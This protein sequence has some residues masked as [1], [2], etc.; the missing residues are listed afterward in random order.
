MRAKLSLT[1]HIKVNQ[2]YI[3]VLLIKIFIVTLFL[4]YRVSNV[5]LILMLLFWIVSGDYLNSLQALRQKKILML[6]I[7]FYLVHVVALLYS[8]NLFNAY[9]ELEKKIPLLLFPLIVASMKEETLRLKR[10]ELLAFY[11]TVT[12]ITCGLLV[13]YAAYR[14]MAEGNVEVFYF[15]EFTALIQVNAIYLAMYVLFA[16]G[17]YFYELNTRSKKADLVKKVLVYLASL[18]VLMFIS[19]KTALAVFILLSLHIVFLQ[20]KHFGRIYRAAIGIAIIL[21]IAAVI[22]YSPV[23]RERIQNLIESDWTG[24]WD[25][26]YTKNAETFTGFTVR[27]S[28]WKAALKQMTEDRV[29]IQ[30][31]GT[32]DNL[33]YLNKAYEEAGLIAAGYTNFN[34]HNAFMEVILEF[35]FAG[36]FFYLF[37][38]TMIAMAAMR[39]KDKAL[40]ILLIIFLFFSMT[41][42]ILYVNKGLVFYS[43]WVSLLLNFIKINTGGDRFSTE[44]H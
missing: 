26:D 12:A 37:I 7:G 28:F 27:I 32:G 33:D 35:G 19:S 10:N 23:T 17:V 2:Q 1:E 38:W 5:A 25:E 43:L 42:S 16:F 6:F 36:L 15:R 20:L 21:L 9:K 13:A 3:Q 4:P 11:T 14:Y 18:M 22:N 24:V 29:L 39:A 40:I 8:D 30:G 34:L 31:I 41:E 44:T